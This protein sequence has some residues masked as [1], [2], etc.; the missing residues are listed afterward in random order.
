MNLSESLAQYTV[1]SFA[2]FLAEEGMVTDTSVGKAS[3]GRVAAG[4]VD[5]TSNEGP[6]FQMAFPCIANNTCGEDDLNRYIAN[7]QQSDGGAGLAQILGAWRSEGGAASGV[8]LGGG[9]RPDAAVRRRRTGGG[10][11]GGIGTP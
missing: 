11:G 4:P 10:G 2:S 7:W 6:S 1:K 5:D 9:A 8:P 3:G